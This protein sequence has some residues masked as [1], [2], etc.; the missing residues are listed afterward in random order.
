MTD[1]RPQR[2]YVLTTEVSRLRGIEGSIL[3]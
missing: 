3:E 1:L 2:I